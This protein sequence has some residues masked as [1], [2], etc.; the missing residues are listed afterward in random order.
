MIKP[1]GSDQLNPL[2]VDD[3][4]LRSEAESLPSITITSAAAA[5]AVM[6]GSGY[7][8]PLTGYMNLADALSA[9]TELK[10]TSGVFF[11][12]PV[13]NRVESIDGL[14]TGQRLA[15][16]DPN[17]D[18]NPVL[19]VMTIEGIDEATQGQIDL[20]T[21]EVYG[22]DDASHPGVGAWTAQGNFFL[23]GP[24]QVLNFSYFCLL[25]TSDAADE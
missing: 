11:P 12:V 20:M 9:S 1:H 10:T 19:A 2:F 8:N 4:T 16:R 5:N 6:L 13:V 24:L 14:A 21:Q 23:S 17:V 7:F 18:G 15:L 25:Y 3:A 22:T